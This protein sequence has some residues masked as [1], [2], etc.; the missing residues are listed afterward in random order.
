MHRLFVPLL[1]D[2]AG[3]VLSIAWLGRLDLYE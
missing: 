1:A 2:L 3:F